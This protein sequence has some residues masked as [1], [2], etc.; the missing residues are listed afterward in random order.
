M[1]EWCT[2]IAPRSMTP[3]CLHSPK[4]PSPHSDAEHFHRPTFLAAILIAS[5]P[6]ATAAMLIVSSHMLIASPF[7]KHSHSPFDSHTHTP[8]NSPSQQKRKPAP[9]ERTLRQR[10]LRQ[11]YIILSF[12]PAPLLLPSTAMLIA[13][14]HSDADLFSL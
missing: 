14:P 11:K 5:P 8:S 3:L 10:S 1:Q 9:K 2:A 13:C 6:I 12:T 7:I 4:P